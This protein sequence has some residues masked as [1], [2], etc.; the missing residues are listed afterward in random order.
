MNWAAVP[1]HEF[2]LSLMG[3][4]AACLADFYGAK[5]HLFRYDH[6]IKDTV[7]ERTEDF[8]TDIQ[9]ELHHDMSGFLRRYLEN[10]AMGKGP[11]VPI[12]ESIATMRLAF[13]A[14]QSISQGKVIGLCGSSSSEG[15]SRTASRPDC[16]NHH[17][18]DQRPAGGN[19][20]S[21]DLV[22]FHKKLIRHFPGSTRSFEG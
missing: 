8:S 9:N 12:S 13:A 19:H 4:K 11:L 21:N 7:L 22:E 14:E 17:P 2:R 20:P 10:L 18:E 15:P 16:H 5:I 3:T 1:G 6:A